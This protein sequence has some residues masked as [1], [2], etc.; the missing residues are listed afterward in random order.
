MIRLSCASSSRISKG[1]LYK[2]T[3]HGLDGAVVSSCRL[4][5]ESQQRRGYCESAEIASVRG[6]ASAEAT[7]RYCERKRVPVSSVMSHARLELSSLG[8]GSYR[9]GSNN[10]VHTDSLREA[11]RTGINVIDTSPNFT[12]GDSEHA[13]GT[14]LEEL[15]SSKELK[16]EELVLMTKV[17]YVEGVMMQD[18]MTS[19]DAFGSVAKLAEN[20]L[21]CLDKNFIHESLES[22]L[23]RLNVDHVDIF[24][25]NNPELLL[26]AS[27]ILGNNARKGPF[28]TEELYTALTD[29]FEFL[30]QCVADGRIGCYGITSGAFGSKIKLDKIVEI[31]EER[32]GDKH[33]FRAIQYPL[34][35]FETSLMESE[36][37]GIKLMDYA[38]G[39]GISQF[40][41][42]PL[43]AIDKSN[44]IRKL[45]D[46][47]FED[48]DRERYHSLLARHFEKA[49]KYE[50]KM[51]SKCQ[52]LPM[53]VRTQAQ[54]LSVNAHVRDNV[55]LLK[56]YLQ[57]A[58]EPSIKLMEHYS[59]TSIE[60]DDTKKLVKNYGLELRLLF[61]MALQVAE[62][63]SA[64]DNEEIKS[65]IDSAVPELKKTTGL[66]EK[67][68]RLL[69]TTN[70]DCVLV[71]MRTP[72]YVSKLYRAFVQEG[73]S[74]LD[75]AS[76]SKVSELL[77]RRY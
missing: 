67:C 16:R 51:A 36:E 15:V 56:F 45:A 55:Q 49:L 12:N 54:Q 62:T 24:Y 72:E 3:V 77:N 68:T 41:N 73:D 1:L 39:K 59:D 52:S 47:R 8:F 37:N 29:A 50:D 44:V 48:G 76:L 38:A 4:W 64:N 25:I 35:V 60:D 19:L 61:K 57:K 53:E 34:N 31:V 11:L 63:Q 28:S 70:V 69:L 26:R 74:P 18:V 58:L 66:S 30:E 23:I 2:H 5:R 32:F 40:I 27:E 22:S 20:R 6:R 21:Y 13:I 17:G 43:T 14:V 42:R 33:H 46:Y 9:I 7:A 65:L 10:S 75:E 71:G